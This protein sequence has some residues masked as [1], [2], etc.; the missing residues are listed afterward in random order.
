SLAM[1]G[2][3]ERS[4]AVDFLHS[5]LAAPKKSRIAKWM[6]WSATGA[7]AVIALSILAYSDLQSKQATLDSLKLK[8][9][10]E[11]PQIKSAEAFVNKVGFAQGWHGGDP[12]YVACLKAITDLVPED[13]QTYATNLIIREKDAPRGDAAKSGSAK[14]SEARNL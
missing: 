5:R 8:L 1:S 11:Q 10:S 2:L 7:V 9:S 12:R 6:I 3:G 4:L 14:A 13:G